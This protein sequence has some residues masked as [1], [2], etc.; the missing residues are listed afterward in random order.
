[1]GGRPRTG[2][3]WIPPGAACT[4]AAAATSRSVCTD[5]AASAPASPVRVTDSCPR[6]R[7]R[8]PSMICCSSASPRE[9]LRLEKVCLRTSFPPNP[10]A[11]AGTWM[12]LS[13]VKPPL[14]HLLS[15]RK[16]IQFGITQCGLPVVRRKKEVTASVR[17]R[18]RKFAVR[19]RL[20]VLIVQ[21]P[22]VFFLRCIAM[23]QFLQALF[24]IDHQYFDMFLYSTCNG[25]R[26][27]SC[28]SRPDIYSEHACRCC[29]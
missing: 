11:M 7:C 28:T 24:L 6:R 12:P 13:R 8:G 26:A 9:Y 20:E 16:L 2:W 14:Q 25:M 1:M 23:T 21:S 27:D 5:L 18:A 22:D 3:R 10:A 4:A 19:S 17:R 15:L 29:A